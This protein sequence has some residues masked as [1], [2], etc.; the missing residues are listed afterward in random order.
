M[1]MLREAFI[2]PRT[3]MIEMAWQC[4]KGGRDTTTKMLNMKVQG[5]RNKGG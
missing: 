3:E 2:E 5:R 4:V 1:D